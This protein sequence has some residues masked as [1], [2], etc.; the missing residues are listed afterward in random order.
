MLFW[1]SREAI[2]SLSSTD[3]AY[4][5]TCAKE[6][7]EC[8]LP[9]TEHGSSELKMT[10][11]RSCHLLC[12]QHRSQQAFLIKWII[13]DTL[14]SFTE[15]EKIYTGV[16]I[17]A[18]RYC[19]WHVNFLWYLRSCLFGNRPQHR[20]ISRD[21][22]YSLPTCVFWNMPLI[23]EMQL[24]GECLWVFLWYLL[25]LMLKRALI[26]LLFLLNL[27]TQGTVRHTWWTQFICGGSF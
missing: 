14:K 11:L 1:L 8:H 23:E 26:A 15:S 12:A 5:C 22:R 4:L 10:R 9:C 27:A 6:R 3:D 2:A 16:V 25:Q 7:T 13:S 19:H 17:K 18:E 20:Y 21:S 24:H